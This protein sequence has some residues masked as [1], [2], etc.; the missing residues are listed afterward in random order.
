MGKPCSLLLALAAVSCGGADGS[1]PNAVPSAGA[2]ATTASAEPTSSATA[3]MSATAASAS[4]AK[5]DLPPQSLD[6]CIIE[7]LRDPFPGQNLPPDRFYPSAVEALAGKPGDAEKLFSEAYLYTGTSAFVNVALF[8]HSEIE[9]KK[10]DSIHWHF[11]IG[12]YERI[13]AAKVV[14][15]LREL[16]LFRKAQTLAAV[17]KREA[18]LAALVELDP[19]GKLG[20]CDASIRPLIAPLILSLVDPAPILPAA[21]CGDALTIAERLA[22]PTLRTQV[23]RRCQ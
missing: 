22:D 10:A 14:E 5:D 20:R 7:V 21:A 6:A 18:A 3:V 9:R 19:R 15:P 16:A 23:G 12:K 2:P 4:T 17:G 8:G 1:D 13:L 11:A